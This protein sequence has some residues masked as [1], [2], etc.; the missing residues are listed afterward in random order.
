MTPIIT[1]DII[2][3]FDK[4]K[5]DIYGYYCWNFSIY[6]NNNDNALYLTEYGVTRTEHKIISTKPYL[7]EEQD[8]KY[9]CPYIK[10][11]IKYFMKQSLTLRR[12][13]FPHVL[14]Y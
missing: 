9:L 10:N 3:S 7:K 11:D 13:Q 5:Y 4:T 14:K 8:I 12:L 1:I 6:D 2:F